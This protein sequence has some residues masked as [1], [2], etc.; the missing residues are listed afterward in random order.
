M[1]VRRF[2]NFFRKGSLKKN[3]EKEK[4]GGK[5]KSAEFDENKRKRLSSR[6]FMYEKRKEFM[7]HSGYRIRIEHMF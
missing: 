7:F 4:K 5:N 1:K 2:R 3:L 6:M